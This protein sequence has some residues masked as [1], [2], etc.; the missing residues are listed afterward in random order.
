[1]VYAGENALPSPESQPTER[2]ARQH[3][4]GEFTFDLDAGFLR[5]GSA[6]VTLRPKAF[7]VLAYL[8]QHHGR[9]VTKVELI[10]F[11]LAGRGCH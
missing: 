5:R 4:F 11:C 7:E 6:E 8:V 1:M 10:E 2:S 3:H 9:L